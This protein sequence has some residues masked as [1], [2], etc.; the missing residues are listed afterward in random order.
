[1]NGWLL[2]DRKLVQLSLSITASLTANFSHN[3]LYPYQAYYLVLIEPFFVAIWRNPIMKRAFLYGTTLLALSISIG[4]APPLTAMD[5]SGVPT[6]QT[7]SKTAEI[8]QKLIRFD[9]TNPPGRTLE[10]AEYLKKIFDA[11]GAETEIIRT[12][13]EGKVHFI[14][15]LKGDSSKKPVL[16]TA[17]S[18]VVPVERKNWSVDPFAGVIK[19][20]Y[21]FGRGA[22]DFKGGQAVFASAMIKLAEDKVPLARDVIFL[23]EADEEAGEY[24]TEW[25]ASKH[26]G[27][28]NAEFALNEGGWILQSPNGEP[29]L[30]NITVQ[31]K[32]YVTFKLTTTG[33]ATHSSRPMPESA[34]SHLV[35]ALTK[36]VE[37]ETDVT[38]TPLTRNYFLQLAKTEKEPLAGYFRTLANSN[39]QNQLREAGRRILELGDY[40]FLWNALIRNTVVPTIINAGYKENVIP[41]TAEAFINVR[42]IPGST[43][44]QMM[45]QL[46]MLIN[47]PVVDI[48]LV[49]AVPENKP[50]STKTELYDALAESSKKVWPKAEVVPA[51]FEAGTDA[52]PWRTRGIPV[53]GIYP[54]PLDNETLERMHGDDERI[55]VR[56][57]DEGTEMIYRTLVKVAG[58]E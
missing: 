1:L 53:Y 25:L 48:K 37:W 49:T 39:D 11:V 13:E 14:A 44:S 41:G 34:I 27:K 2:T 45:K 24:G 28:I 22:L 29:R 26:W 12:P 58:R 32:I 5:G 10:E 46:Q 36:I 50:S 17:H 19:D 18:D 47:D 21:V 3:Y 23:A 20:G 33:K 4:L 56:S 43:P 15:R 16:L 7:V 42:L 30:V 52:G 54:Y 35:K 57:L 9:T 38:L 51:L 40:P 55:S 6:V 8:L 31:D